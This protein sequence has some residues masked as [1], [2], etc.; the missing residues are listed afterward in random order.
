MI[1]RVFI[2]IVGFLFWP[3]N[4]A[5]AG[6]P[7]GCADAAYHQ[8]IKNS[9]A[10][11]EFNNKRQLK[12]TLREYLNSVKNSTNPYRVLSDLS[13][14]IK[15]SAQFDPIDTVE[16]NIEALHDH[17][18]ALRF[19]QQVA[20]SAL[21]GFSNENHAVGVARAWIA[22]RQGDNNLAFEEL[23]ASLELTN[24]AVMASFGPDFNFVRQIYSDGHTTPVLAYL[25]KTEA[26][27]TGKKADDL[28]YIWRH[29]IAAECKVQFQFVD[30]KKAVELNLRVRDVNQHYGL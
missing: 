12:I 20:A 6:Y 23:L 9:F 22:Y 16:A 18:D 21:D 13:Y 4:P 3:P 7:N 8:Y 19:D 1:K 10:Q 15:Y 17:A 11:L 2:T 5:S 25:D 28:R 27:W 30:T 24:S 14:H 26:F 29:M